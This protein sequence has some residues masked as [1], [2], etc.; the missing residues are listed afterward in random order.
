MCKLGFLKKIM[1]LGKKKINDRQG[2][3]IPTS[4]HRVQV[5]SQENYH[6]FNFSFMYLSP[7][8]FFNPIVSYHVAQPI[9]INPSQGKEPWTR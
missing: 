8:T 7:L 5:T 3:L 9:A 2:Y 4:G 6:S 1:E